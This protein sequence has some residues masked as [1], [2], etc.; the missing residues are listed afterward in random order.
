MDLWKWLYPGM[1]VKRWLLLVAVGVLIF[2]LGLN[3]VTGFQFLAYVRFLL[4]RLIFELVGL[5]PPGLARW[6]GFFLLLS[7]GFLIGLGIRQTIHSLFT[8]LLPPSDTPLVEILY[9]KRQLDRGPRIVAIGG[10]TGL[11]SL[12]RGLKKYSSNLT[13]VVTV[14]DDGGSSGRL[15]EELGM[16]PPGDI[17][18][19]LVAL[20]D[21]ESLLEE[22]FQYRWQRG[23][24]L[25]GH[26]FGNLF[27]ATL[28]EVLG[29]FQEAVRQSSRVLAIR[30][31]VLPSTLTPVVLHATY[32][33]GSQGAGE[34]KIPQ[35]DKRIEQVWLEPENAPPV[36]DV[37]RA[38]G[39]A[40]MIVL[41]P[42]SLYTSILPNLLIPEIAMAVRR[43]PGIKVYVCNVMTQP[44][45]TT[46]YTVGDH[47]QA[48]IDHVGPGLIDYVLANSQRVPASLSRKYR[49]EGAAQVRV[50]RERL[51]RLGLELRLKPLMA[52][53]DLARHDP[54]KLA[55]AILEIW[56]QH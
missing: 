21:K 45:E 14:A 6:A 19:T 53:S 15:R 56:A 3:F 17:R 49:A 35:G 52:E 9:E 44:G 32:A 2:S 11:S 37:I 16:L 43:A 42:G 46:D 39:Q 50:D 29:D 31:Q 22:L 41:G 4:S 10:G 5:I 25:A 20:A 7:G 36:G 34:S 33:D 48:I 55:Q 13:A 18:N 54:E 1:G 38:I 28:T 8:T 27:I 12:L 26:T 24:G 47:V 23:E 40:D 51:R 30:G